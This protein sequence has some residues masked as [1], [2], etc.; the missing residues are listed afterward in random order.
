[1]ERAMRR[2]SA[3]K[4]GVYWRAG[5][6]SEA[7]LCWESGWWLVVGVVV[8]LLSSLIQKRGKGRAG[9]PLYTLVGCDARAPFLCGF[10]RGIRVFML[11]YVMSSQSKAWRIVDIPH[12]MGVWP[13]AAHI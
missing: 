12:R 11:H 8:V 3:E 4:R 6:C 10:V 1:M 2:W 5:L 13:L 7:P 9:C